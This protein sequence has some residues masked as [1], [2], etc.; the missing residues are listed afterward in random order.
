MVRVSKQTILKEAVGMDEKK[1][2][3][4]VQFIYEQMCLWIDKNDK[5]ALKQEVYGLGK[6][7]MEYKADTNK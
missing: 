7:L 2:V 1:F 3:G 6:L 5:E 4:C